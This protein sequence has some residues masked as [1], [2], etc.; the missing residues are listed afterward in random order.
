MNQGLAAGIG[1][2]V[3]LFNYYSVSLS[4]VCVSSGRR[5]G[6]RP[7]R[8]GAGL[9]ALIRYLT[10][11]SIWLRRRLLCCC[12]IITGFVDPEAFEGLTT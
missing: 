1:I 6:D 9:G 12:A 4:G 8:P 3:I 11:T 2:A 10:G 7:G 5:H